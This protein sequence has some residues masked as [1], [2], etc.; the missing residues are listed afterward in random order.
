MLV[1]RPPTRPSS[2]T[3]LLAAALMAVVAAAGGVGAALAAGSPSASSAAATFEVRVERLA[4][5]AYRD[6]GDYATQFGPG[7]AGAGTWQAFQSSTGTQELG[8]M[9]TAN[10]AS[11]MVEVHLEALS[12]GAYRDI[13]DYVS[14]LTAARATRGT[15]ELVGSAGGAP[16]L[17]LIKTAD[18]PS[19]MVNVVLEALSGGSYKDVGDY[20]SDFPLSEAGAGTWQM[21]AGSGAPELALIATGSGTVT[22]HLDALSGGAYQR[23]GN[24]ATSFGSAGASNGIWRL[25]GASGGAPELGFASLGPGAI[26]VR[27]ETLSG[28]SYKRAGSYTSVFSPSLAGAGAWQLFG[29]GPAPLLALVKPPSPPS[30]TVS[31]PVPVTVT[32]VVTEPLPAPPPSPPHRRGHVRARLTIS[33]RYDFA[34]TRILRVG[35][36]RFPRDARLAVRCYGHGCPRLAVAASYRRLDGALRSLRGRVLRAGDLLKITVTAPDLLAE[37]IG[38]RIRNGE[39]PRARL[40]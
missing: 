7:L 24:Y 12:G 34:R 39:K 21:V 8:L 32:T 40:L 36:S 9:Q 1:P 23:V 35:I 5:G 2:L 14:G 31:Q 18:T 33:Y 30:T 11:G 26:A 38:V 28:G 16:E 3:A 6:A 22:V 15:L 20:R 17:A 27:W 13:G 19:K 25:F 4:G 37:Q 29:S 10:T